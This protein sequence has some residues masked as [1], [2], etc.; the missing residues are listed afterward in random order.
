MRCAAASIVPTSSRRRGAR[1]PALDR[2]HIAGRRRQAALEHPRDA[3]ALLRVLQLG[4]LRRHILRQIAFLEDPLG[5]VFEGRHHMVGRNRQVLRDRL[6]AAGSAS[7][8]VTLRPFAFFVRSATGRARSACRR[9]ANRA[10]RSSAAGFRR[11]TICPGRNAAA[12]PAQTCR[13]SR[14]IS[15]IGERRAW[16]ARRRP[17]STPA[18]SKSSMETKVGSPPM[19]RRTSPA[20]SAASTFSP[21]ASSAAQRLVRKRLGDARMFGDAVDPHVEAEFD[22]G[23]ARHAGD[24]CGVA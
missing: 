11:D 21:S 12:R 8:A 18:D 15:L 23:K 22:L 17:Y 5:R 9:A 2:Q 16:S 13:A 4:V 20:C 7:S 6:P 24:R 1:L 14:R 3:V 19:V 10:R